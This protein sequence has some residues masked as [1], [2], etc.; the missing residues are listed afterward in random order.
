[1][2]CVIIVWYTILY[3]IADMYIYIYIH[4]HTHMCIST[5]IYIYI[6][7]R[8]YH[9]GPAAAGVFPHYASGPE[10]NNTTLSNNDLDKPT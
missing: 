7:V 1:M 2:D 9:G 5:Y 6:Y 3:Y 4:T 8:A 10:R